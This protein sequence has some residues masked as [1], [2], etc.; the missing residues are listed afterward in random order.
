M[1]ESCTLVNGKINNGF[2]C[3]KNGLREI[4]EDGQVII[5]SSVAEELLPS[6]SGFFFGSYD[7]DEY[8][9][10]DLLHT[11]DIIQH[12]LDETDFETESIFYVSSW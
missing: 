10:D 9:V 6:R 11:I 8:Y 12:V 7:Y 4:L 1:L 5:D 3:T 2:E